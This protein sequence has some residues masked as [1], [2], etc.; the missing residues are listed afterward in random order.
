MTWEWIAFLGL[1]AAWTT[2][3][4]WLHYWYEVRKMEF[5]PEDIRAEVARKAYTDD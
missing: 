4:T 5:I 1:M 3:Q 2:V